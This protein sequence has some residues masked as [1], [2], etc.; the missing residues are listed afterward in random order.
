MVV[1]IGIDSVEVSRFFLWNTFKTEK[2][3]RIFSEQEIEYCLHEK[4]KSSE[5]F[6][7]RFAAREAFFKA[8]GYLDTSKTIPF[9]TLCKK[10]RVEKNTTGIPHLIID[11]KEIGRQLAVDTTGLNAFISLTHTKESATAVV[12]LEKR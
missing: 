8:L 1:G 4:H 2:L 10:I 7:V 6:A 5:R 3:I 11:W 9:L 12:V